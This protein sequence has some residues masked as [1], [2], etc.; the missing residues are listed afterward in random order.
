MYEQLLNLST[1]EFNAK[2]SSRLGQKLTESHRRAISIANK[3][4]VV[5]LEKRK[6]L[7]IAN[8]GKKP[9]EFARAYASLV[10]KGVPKSEEHC[11]KIGLANS[12][13]I[14]T[15]KGIF[16][17]IN[18]VAAEYGVSRISVH[19]WLKNNKK[20][21]SYADIDVSLKRIS[22]P[23]GVFQNISEVA[24]FFNVSKGTVH[25]WLKNKKEEFYRIA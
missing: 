11:I 9:T 6:K 7:S 22:T 24:K 16:S 12:K 4:K 19:K 17:N 2:S 1:N 8:E 23:E 21:F 5:S 10:H 15:P 18:A 20:E 13:R 3:G 14:K 25:V